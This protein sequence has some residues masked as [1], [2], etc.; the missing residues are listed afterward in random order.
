MASAMSQWMAKD[1]NI[2]LKIHEDRRGDYICN[3]YILRECSNKTLR[4]ECR[5]NRMD[6]NDDSKIFPESWSWTA[7]SGK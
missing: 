7:E 2:L 4:H 5:I 6:Y 1:R 3:E